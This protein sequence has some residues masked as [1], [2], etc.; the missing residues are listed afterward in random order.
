MVPA[1]QYE[2]VETRLATVGPVLY[3]VSIDKSG[4]S[5]AREAT[6]FVSNA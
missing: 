4:V 6:T 3:M 1:K 5:T 2:V